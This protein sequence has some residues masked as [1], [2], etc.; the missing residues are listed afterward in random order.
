MKDKGKS[1]EGLALL[2]PQL[3]RQRGWEEQLDLHSIFLNW[4]EILDK[5]IAEHCR[6]LKIVKKQLWIEVENSAWMQQFQYQTVFILDMLNKSLKRTRLQGLRFCVAEKREGDGEEAEPVLRYVQPPPEDIAAFESCT[7]SI[8]DKA[9]RES[10]IRFW[11]LSQAC[12]KE[13]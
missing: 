10:L 2:L 9:V 8:P 1:L 5:E 3:S 6:P 12:K 7:E 11:Y 13:S 4:S